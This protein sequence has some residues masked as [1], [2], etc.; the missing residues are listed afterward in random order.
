MK[1]LDA[2]TKLSSLSP[3]DIAIVAGIPTTTPRRTILDLIEFGE[4]LSLVAAVLND[5]EKAGSCPAIDIEINQLAKRRGF[6]TAHNPLSD[7]P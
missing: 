7:V 4:D 6:N 5:A 2:I 3:A 1:S